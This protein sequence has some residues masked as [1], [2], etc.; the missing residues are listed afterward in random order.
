MARLGVQE[1]EKL[2]V[3]K[4][5]NGLSLYIQKV[6][7]FLTISTL[8]DAFH[9]TSKLE[10][11]HKGKSRFMTKPTG[12]T[13]DKK[14]PID[15]DKS[16]YPSQ[17]TSPKQDHGKKHSQKDKRDHSKQP[18]IGK[19][20]DYHNSSWHDTSECNA[21]KTFLEK[22]STFDLSDKTLVESNPEASTLLTLTSTTPKA[23]TIVNKEE[24]EHSF[25]TQAWFKT[26]HCI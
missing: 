21:R 11:K 19:W 14:S 5:V 1:E 6:M 24:Q 9:Y 25:H 16:R 8:A 7:E 15:S 2:L 20:Y 22:L 10:A 12:R 17:W 23:S 18:S 13:S 26:I 3:L 4:Y